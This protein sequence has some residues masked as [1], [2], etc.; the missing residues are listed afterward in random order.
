MSYCCLY[1]TYIYKVSEYS[2]AAVYCMNRLLSF[3]CHILYCCCMYNDTLLYRYGDRPRHP[4]LD[5]NHSSTREWC[6]KPIVTAARSPPALTSWLPQTHCWL[7]SLCNCCGYSSCLSAVCSTCS[8][9]PHL[10]RQHRSQTP[11]QP[12]YTRRQSVYW[13]I[14]VKTSTRRP[15]RYTAAVNAVRTAVERQA[16]NLG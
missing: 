11:A 15:R 8:T 10:R 12:T 6:R 3:C 5:S 4:A 7:S 1:M 2:T 14:S 16:S 13:Y 9:A